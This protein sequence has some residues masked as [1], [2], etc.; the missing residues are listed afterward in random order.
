MQCAA[1]DNI[2]FFL[3]FFF[4]VPFSRTGYTLFFFLLVI[5]STKEIKKNKIGETVIDLSDKG[6]N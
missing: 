5:S 2:P 6:D 4:F 1:I 3:S